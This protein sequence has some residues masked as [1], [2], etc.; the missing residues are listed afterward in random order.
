MDLGVILALLGAKISPRGPEMQPQTQPDSHLALS[1]RRSRPGDANQP[2]SPNSYRFDPIFELFSTP[3]ITHLDHIFIM[4]CQGDANQP[5]S[6]VVKA[7][8]VWKADAHPL[9]KKRIQD[10]SL[11]EANH[12]NHSSQMFKITPVRNIETQSDVFVTTHVC[13]ANALPSKKE[14]TGQKPS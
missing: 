14:N 12:K 5:W 13:N 8:Q 4:P 1:W 2:W 9:Q 3:R 7:G 10:E 6:D 11:L